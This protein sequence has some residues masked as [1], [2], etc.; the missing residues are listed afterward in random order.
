[1]FH[2]YYQRYVAYHNI[3][4]FLV[5]VFSLR[6]SFPPS[7]LLPFSFVSLSH[8]RTLDYSVFNFQCSNCL[9][10]IAKIPLQYLLS[11]HA[12]ALTWIKISYT[13]SF[14][15]QYFIGGKSSIFQAFLVPILLSIHIYLVR[16]YE[17]VSF[18]VPVTLFGFS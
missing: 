9:V 8:T 5:F 13:I 10:A 6:L 12:T 15:Y 14:P 3:H 7:L 17:P 18:L 1:M 16:Q 11:L 4:Y 2:R